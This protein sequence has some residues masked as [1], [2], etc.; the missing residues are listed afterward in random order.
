MNGFFIIIQVIATLNGSG[1]MFQNYKTTTTGDSVRY[2]T[3]ENCESA[4]AQGMEARFK[5]VKY[6]EGYSNVLTQQLPK[7]GIFANMQ[8]VYIP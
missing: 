2:K 5:L 3:I 8:C 7:D 1:D 6:K 4:L